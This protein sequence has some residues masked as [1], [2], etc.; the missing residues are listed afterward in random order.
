[1]Y[2][3]FIKFLLWSLKIAVII[4]L[5]IITQCTNKANNIFIKS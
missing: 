2:V 5:L 4:Q 3:R 1:M